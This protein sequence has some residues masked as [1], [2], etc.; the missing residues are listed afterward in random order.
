MQLSLKPFLCHSLFNIFLIELYQLLPTRCEN[1]F[2]FPR[3]IVDEFSLDV[4]SSSSKRKE[5]ELFFFLSIFD[6]SYFFPQQVVGAEIPSLDEGEGSF[7]E[8]GT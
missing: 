4:Q 5:R 8:R 7:I 2:I 3:L 6:K 1:V